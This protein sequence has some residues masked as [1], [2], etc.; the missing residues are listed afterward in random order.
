MGFNVTEKIDS[1]F[2]MEQ[3][4]KRS[5]GAPDGTQSPMDTGNTRDLF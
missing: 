2:F 4:G 1:Y 5:D 3:A